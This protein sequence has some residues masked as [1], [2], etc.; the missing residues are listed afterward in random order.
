MVDLGQT[1]LRDVSESLRELIRTHITELTNDDAILFQ[2]PGEF[3]PGNE[4]KLL[5]YLYNMRDNPY[6]LN[7]LSHYGRKAEKTVQTPA[8]LA[9]DLLYMFVPYAKQVELEL[10]I[11]DKLKRLFYDIP[12]LKNDNL[13]GSLPKTG[14]TRIN[15]VPDNPSLDTLRNIWMGFPNKSHKLTLLYLLTP[16]LI[17]SL[18]ERQ[19]DLVTQVT[20]DV[21]PEQAKEG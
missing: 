12:V 3:E 6:L 17:P 18:L 21:S 9:M 4:A 14:N 8:S 2:S 7:A 16:V 13:Q 1:V 20:L 5:V 10:I 19:V 11:A 15:I